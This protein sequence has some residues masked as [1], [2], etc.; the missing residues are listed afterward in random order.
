MDN[1][2]AGS[3]PIK[4]RFPRLE[5]NVLRDLMANVTLEEARQPVFSTS[6]LKALG[7]DGLHGK[8]YQANWEIVGS[9]VFHLVKYVF[10]GGRLD[11]SINKTLI[12]FIL[13]VIGAEIIH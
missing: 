8:F 6:P 10:S 5:D 13:K 7:V 12:V 11:L 3:F 1:Y 4:G 2:L 9:N